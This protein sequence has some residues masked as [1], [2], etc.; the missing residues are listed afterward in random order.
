MIG[1]A[2][3]QVY[4]QRFVST[5]HLPSDWRHENTLSFVV[6]DSPQSIYVNPMFIDTW[7]RDA[8]N[9]SGG[10]PFVAGPLPRHSEAPRGAP[11]RC[12]APQV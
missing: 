10:S 8:M 6:I 11:Y 2:E 4:L 3:A 1:S 9:I 5:T 7:N 12:V